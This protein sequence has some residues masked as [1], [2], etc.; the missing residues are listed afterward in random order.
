[1]VYAGTSNWLKFTLT[2]PRGRVVRARLWLLVIV[3]VL[4]S[5]GGGGG[6]TAAADPQPPPQPPPPPPPSAGVLQ[7]ESA[8]YEVDES[9]QT[10]SFTVTRTGGSAGRVT[11]DIS[12][13]DGTA[14]EGEDYGAMSTTAE[15]EDGET[16]AQTGNFIIFDNSVHEPV[17]WRNEQLTTDWISSIA[18]A[19]EAAA[20]SWLYTAT[21][22]VK[23]GS[24][25]GFSILFPGNRSI[26]SAFGTCF[27]PRRGTLL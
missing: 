12:T 23:R 22:A 26:R 10:V 4:Q 6:E 7:L 2:T 9:T 19:G 16:Q 5:C 17:E 24:A 3:A 20:P 27:R 25:P 13:S 1:M 11:V 18:H 21:P 14:L 15:F 8:T